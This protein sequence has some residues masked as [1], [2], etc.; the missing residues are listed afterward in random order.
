MHIK[1]MRKILIFLFSCFF[2][3]HAHDIAHGQSIF[4]AKSD[5]N[6]SILTIYSSLEEVLAEP[7]IAVFQEQNP[8]IEIQY[9]DLQ[10]LDIYERVIQESDGGQNTADLVISSAMDLQVKLVNDGYALA[11]RPTDPQ[12]PSWAKWQDSAFGLTFEPSVIVY[13]KTK[14]KT[15]KPPANRS[16]LASLLKDQN[17]DLFGQ[18]G[19]YDIERSGL[20]FLF[21]ARDIEHDRD[22][23]SL[24]NAMGASGVKLYPSSASILERVSDGKLSLGYNILGSYAQSWAAT[25]PDLGIILPEDFTVVMTRIALVP[26]AAENPELSAQFLRFLMSEKGQ[27]IM[28]EDLELAAVHPAIKGDNTASAFREKFGTR[29]RPISIGPGLVAYL[30]QVKRARFFERWNRALRG[31]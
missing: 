28:A 1:P 12:W 6:S 10:T 16:E 30:D 7:L 21:L 18:M 25:N 19:T 5:Q 23:W 31:E 15:S 13:N 24:V 2:S 11:I 9:Y 8:D 17:S 29:L 14:F 26:K 27:R 4:P 22:I 20:G 3:I